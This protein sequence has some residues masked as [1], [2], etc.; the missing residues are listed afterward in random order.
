MF[1]IFIKLGLALALAAF[2]FRMVRKK[3]ELRAS[4][5]P[6]PAVRRAM[7]LLNAMKLEIAL[8]GALM[9]CSVAAIALT[10]GPH[11]NAWVALAVLSAAFVVSIAIGLW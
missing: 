1:P 7:R 3:Q 8:A 2:V 10:T 9:L 5:L 4:G 6:E 11:V